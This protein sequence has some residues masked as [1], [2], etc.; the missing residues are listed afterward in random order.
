MPNFI[1]SNITIVSINLGL[2]KS[3]KKTPQHHQQQHTVIFPHLT[4]LGLQKSFKTPLIIITTSQR[5][6]QQQLPQ[7]YG[8]P[9]NIT[10]QN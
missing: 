6:Q 3:L 7:Y 10:E 2:L 1:T 8:F 5:H 4:H 9:K